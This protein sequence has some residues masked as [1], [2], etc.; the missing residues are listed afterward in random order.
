MYEVIYLSKSLIYISLLAVIKC[1]SF[2]GFGLDKTYI[3]LFF[4]A[5]ALTLP[6]LVDLFA[7]FNPYGGRLLLHISIL[8]TLGNMFVDPLL[9]MTVIDFTNRV[10]ILRNER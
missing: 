6:L 10:C 4:T 7:Y 1:W 5:V 2:G 9:A 3:L 8:R